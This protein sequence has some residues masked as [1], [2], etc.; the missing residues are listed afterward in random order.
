MSINE[1]QSEWPVIVLLLLVGILSVLATS[2][3]PSRSLLKRML[4]EYDSFL[5]EFN[6]LIRLFG[7]VAEK[8]DEKF[9]ASQ[10]DKDEVYSLLQEYNTLYNK[11]LLC[12]DHINECIK[13]KKVKTYKKHI[14][15]ASRIYIRI[16]QIFKALE[17]IEERML[18]SE[19]YY[20]ERIR[21][22]ETIFEKAEPE[23]E[24]V[25][26]PA[27]DNVPSDVFF[28]GCENIEQIEKRYKSLAKVYHPD[29]PTGDKVTFQKVY[30]EY[31]RKKGALWENN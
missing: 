2:S 28:V 31:E 5:E 14:Q 22:E 26:P 30:D 8:I 4:D 21:Y 29:M 24:L 16:E 9:F 12:V 17:H 3:K 15:N 20:R 6:E 25:E 1:I 7:R 18:T 23:E 13:R 27:L 11:M 10:T 19:E